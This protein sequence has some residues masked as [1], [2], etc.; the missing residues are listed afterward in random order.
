MESTGLVTLLE[1]G[2]YKAAQ[3]RTTLEEVARELPRVGKPR[4]LAQLLRLLG[5]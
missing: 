4:P 2:I 5:D 1:D 3:G